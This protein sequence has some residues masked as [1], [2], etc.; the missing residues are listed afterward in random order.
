ME[1]RYTQE[2]G[3]YLALIYYYTKLNGHPP[4]ERDMQHYF[5]VTPPTV[6]QMVITLEDRGLISREPGQPRS[7]QVLLPRDQLPDLE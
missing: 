4:A 5:K 1:S 6:H 2:Q 3:Q 7:I